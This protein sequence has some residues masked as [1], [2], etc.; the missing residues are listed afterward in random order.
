MR[1][2]W[3]WSDAAARQR[4][5]AV[6]EEVRLSLPGGQYLAPCDVQQGALHVHIARFPGTVD[7][8]IAQVRA[9]GQRRRAHCR[10]GGA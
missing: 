5:N 3:F 2:H 9:W 1:D 4:F 7:E 10:E 6:A 8:A